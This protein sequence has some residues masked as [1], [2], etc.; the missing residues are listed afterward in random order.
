MARCCET[1]VELEVPFHD[2]DPLRV[3]WHGH[4]YKYLELARTELLRSRGI[5]LGEPIGKRFRI[6]VIESRCRYAY[7]LR[8]GDRARVTAWIRDTR[9]RIVISYEVTNLTQGRRSARGQ[10]ILA[11]VDTDGNLQLETPDEI[12]RCLRE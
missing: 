7:P 12:R 11:T 4:Y 10:T 5:D 3:V 6:F 8:Y 1:S 2:V 9:R